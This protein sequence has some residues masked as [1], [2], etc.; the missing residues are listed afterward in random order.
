MRGTIIVIV[1]LAG[2]AT[3][4]PSTS[5]I[6][7][8]D[9]NS[10]GTTTGVALPTGAVGGP[11]AV[12]AN[13]DSAVGV[14]DGICYVGQMGP[15]NFPA[16]GYCTRDNSLGTV[17]AE[18]VDCGDGGACV[19]LGTVELPYNICV[20][21]ADLAKGCPEHQS[22]MDSFN[23]WAMDKVACVP[24]NIDAQDGVACN[25]FYDCNA[26][27]DC[28]ID[29]E[30]PNGVCATYGCDSIHNTGCNGGDCVEMNDYPTIGALCV[31]TCTLDSDCA[32][33]DEG[34]LC[35][36]GQCRAVHI[37]DSCDLSRSCGAGMT[38]SATGFCTIEGCP[39]PGT[40]E[41]CTSGS[42]CADLDGVHEC[43]DRCATIGAECDGAG[44]CI[45][46]GAPNGGACI[47]AS[48]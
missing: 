3:Q 16:E 40:E 14:H 2:C 20:G 35:D 21:A 48:V 8:S 27:S 41:G 19:N 39:N 17:C 44:S 9:T 5:E 28:D 26:Y 34:Y 47:P 43:V 23:G 12:D 29:V 37:G 1:A 46:V 31:E 38:C 42:I 36:S 33:Q 45:D 6:A 7:S 11:C 18:D 15:S 30:H 10:T 32:R 24:G 4:D 22:I 25:G 13:C